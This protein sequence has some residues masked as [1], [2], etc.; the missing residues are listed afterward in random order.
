ME[1]V[2]KVV[3]KEIDGVGFCS[4]T[5]RSYDSSGFFQIVYE[6]GLTE[7]SE[8]D[9]VVALV[10]GEGKSQET[11]V[12]LKPRVGRRGRK[13]S[14]VV[15]IDEIKR[16]S[17]G[18]GKEKLQNEVNVMR[19]V[20]LNDVIEEDSG[21]SDS[22]GVGLGG[23]VDLN[24][25]PVE[26]LGRTWEC[27]TDL[28]RA[29]PETSTGFDLNTGL[30]W[31]L[32]EGLGLVNVDIDYEEN[33]SDKRRGLIDLNIDASCDL[34]NA[35]DC[36][37]SG[38]KRD[39]EFDLNLEV[40]AEDSKDDL[41][42]QP[43]G[44]EIVQETNMQAENGVQDNLE[45]GEYKEVHVAEV[46]R[47]QLLEQM[48]KQ[49]S[50]SL[51]DLNTRDS[52]GVE[53][54]HDLPEHDA[55]T[56]DESLSERQISN[57]CTSGRSKRRKGSDNPKFM[58]QP[59]LRRSARRMLARSPVNST[60]T[61]CLVDEVSPSPSV[62]SLTEEKP[63]IVDGKAENIS[64]LLPKPQLPPSSRILD[65]DGLPILDVFTAYS[66]LRCFSTLLFLSPFELKD[67]VEA[68]RCMSP[69]LLFDSI[70]VSVLQILRKHL[71]QL[72]AEGDLSASAC[73]RYAYYF[74][75]LVMLL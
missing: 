33:C 8:L 41:F 7:I 9:E 37:L 53:G 67:F 64:V 52:N 35:G 28:N 23:N 12:Q 62:S 10:M 13:R 34:D 47:A 16:D 4:G 14:R 43:N 70:H 17:S 24:C 38:Q 69:S 63:W 20:D 21:V 61:A 72:A 30:D 2:G 45:T 22:F 36:A 50:V 59:R 6:N 26:T 32:N 11:S 56:V 71:K 68:L 31:S 29:V 46:S 60:V 5:V 75:S 18:G 15:R 73:L 39:G 54:D 42:I 58:S 27:V 74:L 55:K 1:L 51:Q 65:L 19:N 49:N 25:G 40:N 48:Q 57:E 66:C 44:N 3:R